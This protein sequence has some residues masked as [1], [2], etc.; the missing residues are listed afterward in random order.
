[1]IIRMPKYGYIFAYPKGSGDV[2]PIID[3]L[4]EDAHSRDQKLIMRGLT[5]KTLEE[6]EPVYGDRF[7]IEENREDADYIYTVEKLRDLRGRKLSSKRN[8]I[9]HFERNGEWEF[10]LI[11]SGEDIDSAR[12]FVAEFY[13]EKG[14][15]DLV[16][17]AD[18]IEQMFENYEVLGFFGG[19]LYQ[20]GEPVAFTAATQ[21]DQLTMDVHFE[22][23]LPGVEGAYTMINREFVKAISEKFP[24][25]EYINREEDMGLEGLRK[26]K[27]SYHP[28]VLLMKYTAYENNYIIRPR[29]ASDLEDFVSLRRRVFGD[30]AEFIEFF[31]ACFRDDYLDF[32]IIEDQDGGETLQASLTQFDMG[33]LVV[34]EGKVSD[35]AGKSIEMSYAICTDPAARG[36]GYGSHITVYAREIAESSRKLSML[37]PAEPS[38][39]KFY[40]PLEYKK[41]MYAEQGSVLASEH[42]DFEFSHLQTKVLTPQEYNNYRE[43]ILANRVHIKLSEGALRFAA[44]W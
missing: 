27:E 18:A 24:D 15:P 36:K 11:E 3:E 38:L 2:K 26:A 28:D 5:P 44:G 40:E 41:F 25:V 16:K 6:F 10:K 43:T 21:L 42:V 37:S 9:K 29:E 1:M 22:K 20:N 32:L 8:H 33:K 31:D 17:E 30:D 23:A 7:T 19:L 35:I 39:I 13:K 4:L 34:P 14:D 12:E